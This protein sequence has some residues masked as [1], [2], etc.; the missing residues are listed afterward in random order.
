MEYFKETIKLLEKSSFYYAIAIGMDGRYMYVSP[1]Y[2]KNFDFLKDSLLGKPFEVTLHAD[3]IKIC[4]EVGA[5]CF[6]NPELL[7]PAT[8]RKHDGKGGYITTQWELKAIFDSENNPVGIFCIGYNI[9]EYVD[10]RQQLQTAE[11]EIE[12]KTDLLNQ[13]GYLQAHVIRKPLANIMGLTQV[14][15]N[16]EVDANMQTIKTLLVN[17]ATELDAV[18]K[19]IITK[20][21]E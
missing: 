8:L 14:I 18:V 7:Y 5:R 19:D 16:M 17:S 11:S 21:G 6:E 9:T 4:A 12:Q 3:D 2:D 20:A 13:I 10:T 1:N 15:D